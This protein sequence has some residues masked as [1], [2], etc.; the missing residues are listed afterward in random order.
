MGLTA[1]LKNR[2]EISCFDFLFRSENFAF[3]SKLVKKK[4]KIFRQNNP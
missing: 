2:F 4:A 1:V 3:D